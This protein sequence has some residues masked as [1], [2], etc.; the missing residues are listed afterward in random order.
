MNQQGRAEPEGLPPPTRAWRKPF[1]F[2]PTS[3][4]A[5]GGNGSAGDKF[6]ALVDTIAAA[7]DGHDQALLVRGHPGSSDPGHQIRS[8]QSAKNQKK[9]GSRYRDPVNT[10]FPR[11]EDSATRH[12]LSDMRS[13]R[14]IERSA[15]DIPQ[16]H[17][18]RND[19][20][21]TQQRVGQICQT[22]TAT[23][24][25]EARLCP[26]SRS[27]RHPKI[28]HCNPVAQSNRATITRRREHDLNSRPLRCYY[29]HT[30]TP[31]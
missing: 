17:G 1:G 21:E 6:A 26:R 8:R 14:Q 13:V 12:A 10:A 25:L 31:A 9:T 5:G 15:H 19:L 23:G 28:A 29:R 27:T 30:L 24:H 20:P 4:S 3:R 11:R 7:F 18:T 22:D 2:R 16:E